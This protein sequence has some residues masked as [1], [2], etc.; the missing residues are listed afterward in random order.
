MR[1]VGP[2]S[3]EQSHPQPAE[4]ETCDFVYKICKTEFFCKKGICVTHAQAYKGELGDDCG[5]PVGRE[6]EH[7]L[8]CTDVGRGRHRPL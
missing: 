2:D 8:K 3:Q 4:G 7:G 1:C 5:E 6:C